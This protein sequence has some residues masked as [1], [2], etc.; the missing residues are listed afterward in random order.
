MQFLESISQSALVLWVA[1]S[2]YGYPIILT[3]HSLGMAL[4][5]GIMIIADLRVLGVGKIISFA[6]LRQF[7][8]VAWI[9]LLVNALSG[10]L[11][12]LANYSAFLTNTAFLSKIAMLIVGAIFTYVLV[13]IINNKEESQTFPIN[14]QLL[15]FV[16]LCLWLGSIIAGRVVG[17]TSIPM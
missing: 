9:G 4:V 8:L 12:F 14:A 16:C 7:F 1:E 11:L 5:V 17:Y 2:N 13:K 6:A 15:A 10:T 3:L